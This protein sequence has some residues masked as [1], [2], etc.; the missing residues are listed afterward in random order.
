MGAT[1]RAQQA[2]LDDIKHA[3]EEVENHIHNY[4]IAFGL[5]SD[6]T[7]ETHVAK[8]MGD[9]AFDVVSGNDDWG[10]WV[11]IL[12]SED[13]PFR[14]GKTKYD[15]HH[16]H[17][18]DA[19]DASM[20]RIQIGFGESGAAALASLDITEQCYM[21]EA[22]NNTAVQTQI[23]SKRQDVGTKAWIRVWCVGANAK[24]LSLAFGIHE[25]DE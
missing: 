8:E 4:E 10:A 20:F 15:L 12:G 5:A 25:Y 23:I 13:T 19:N 1:F 21:R 7:P 18:V 22:A 16:F 17:V 3:A 6:A 11:Q 2:I 14:V 9:V 24:T